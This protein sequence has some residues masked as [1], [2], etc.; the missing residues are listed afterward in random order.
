M[1][2]ILAVDDTPASLK[3]LTDTMTAEG[4]QVRAA[5]SGELALEATAS[6]P[7]ELVLLDIRMPGMD[8]FEVSR[9]LK[10]RPETRDIPVIFIS[11][12]SE[13]VDKVLGFELG[14]VDYVTKPYQREE[15]LARVRT[16]LELHRLRQHFEGM[17]DERT[18]ELRASEETLH[19][20]NR[21]LR[22][23]SNCNQALLR[24][25]DE[26]ALLNDVCRIICDEAGYRMAWVGY[27]EHDD[28]KT[29]RPVRRRLQQRRK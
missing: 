22:A 19:R 14:A 18:A 5:L 13:T 21:K 1:G 6:E 3:L 29:I 2:D 15:L 25:V 10:A 23:I 16:H 9:R 12:L 20:L 26:Q 28:A 8:G 4:Y 11:A 24:A 7:P 27:A 17:V